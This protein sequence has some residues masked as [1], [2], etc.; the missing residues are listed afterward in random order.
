MMNYSKVL[1]KLKR[2]D[3]SKWVEVLTSKGKHKK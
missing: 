1:S 2:N 3:D